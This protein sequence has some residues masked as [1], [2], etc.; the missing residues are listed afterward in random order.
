MTTIEPTPWREALAAIH[1]PQV[2][3]VLAVQCDPGWLGP[4]AAALR[5][6]IDEVFA[7]LAMSV[8]HVRIDRIVLHSLPAIG[9]VPPEELAALNAAHADWLS[10]LALVGVLLPAATRP[11]VHRLIVG[12]GQRSV[13]VVDGI[14]L[15]INGAWP[16][17]DAAATALGIVRRAGATT[18]L[19]GY[20]ID[21]DGPFGDADPSI[22]L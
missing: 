18:P 16:H 10:R 2:T 12:G 21:M 19:T 22:Y 4:A 13:G 3:A 6:E 14:E 8:R 7:A 20:D 15:Q 5:D 1:G 11:R 17:P 9:D